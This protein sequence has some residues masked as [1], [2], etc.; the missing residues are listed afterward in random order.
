MTVTYEDFIVGILT[1]FAVIC[2]RLVLDNNP[3]IFRGTFWH[4]P[5][6]SARNPDKYRGRSWHFSRFKNDILRGL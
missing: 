3:D 6:F 5:R 2:Q 1:F 4:F